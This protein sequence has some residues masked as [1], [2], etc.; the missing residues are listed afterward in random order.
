MLCSLVDS[1]EVLHSKE[2][3]AV[4]KAALRM[5]VWIACW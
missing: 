1:K 5:A 4:K 3:A 2:T